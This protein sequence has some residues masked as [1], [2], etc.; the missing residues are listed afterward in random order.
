[1]TSATKHAPPHGAR[2]AAQDQPRFLEDKLRIPRLSLAVLR[3]RRVTELIEQAAA[4]RV[5]LVSGPAG[6]GKTVACASWAAA[7][8]AARRVAWLTVDPED[9]DPARF[10]AYARAALARAG[11][12]PA[13]AVRLLADV[14]PA[15]FP[16]RLVEAAQLFTEPVVLVLDDIHEI[17]GGAVLAGL[18]LLIRHAPPSVRLVLSGRCPP[19][20][21]LARL[22]VAGELADVTAAELACTADEAA[23]YFAMLGI[24]VGAAGRDELLRRTEGWMAGLR[25]AAMR[26]RARPATASITDLAGN[27]PM[28]TDYL[29]DEVLGRQPPETRLFLLRTSVAELVSGDLADALTGEP[30]GARMLDRLSRDNSFVQAPGGDHAAYRYHPLLREV[31]RSDLQREIPHEIPVLLRRAARWHAASGRAIDAVRYSAET[32]DWD[33][34]AH[35]LTESATEIL[36]MNGP[37]ALDAV[38]SLLPADR[39][40]DDVAVASALAAARLWSGDPDGAAV[41]LQNAQRGLGR[42]APAV[43]RVAEPCLAA[44]GVMQAA[45]RAGPDPGQLARASALAE[46]QQQNAGTLA[47]HRALGLLWFTLGT[48]RLR[49]WEIS[50]ARLALGHA[51]CQLEAGGPAGLLA[52]ARGWHALAG[53]WHGETAAR[54]PVGETSAA[55]ADAPADDPAAAWLPA[56]AS[57]QLCLVSDDLAGAA[58]SLDEFDHAAVAQLPGEPL[59]HIL[60]DL[61]RARVRL[62]DGDPAGARSLLIRMGDRQLPPDP[63]LQRQLAVLAGEIALRSG[64]PAAARTALGPADPGACPG[65]D[66]DCVMQGRLLLAEGDFGAA[67]EMVAGCQDG[68]AGAAGAVAGATLLEKIAGLLVA[69]VARRR[70]GQPGRAAEVLEQALALAEPGT[71]LRPFLDAGPPV[72]SAIT[73]LVPPTSGSAR[74]AAAV[75]E[76]F[77]TQL[78]RVRRDPE[79]ADAPLTD[80]ELAVLRFLPSHMTNQEIAEALFLSINT[81]KTHLRSVYRKLGVASRRAAIA[82]GRRLGL[83]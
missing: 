77:D 30:G 27:E 53:A 66:G 47:E 33:Y 6:A 28:V 61:I 49:R 48:A 71:A 19:G 57:A 65:C 5:T 11:T 24:N 81:V 40:A 78:P 68:A 41:H 79:Q 56:L 83:L 12:L 70:L 10:W 59:A 72:R 73:V 8:P 17:A 63:A 74:F 36:L 22:R 42:C 9:A 64:D 39:A 62:A 18:D 14:S 35:V 54:L 76:R 26:A 29:R 37:A 69:V 15:E 51:E 60:A 43:R 80:S 13:E 25:L 1:M 50:A 3:R 32:G 21:Q 82:Q 55:A 16:L 2:V 45:G 46:R 75:L 7:T 31:L 20:L 44:L 38:L 4:H 52:R 23:A 34:A 58:R 67:I